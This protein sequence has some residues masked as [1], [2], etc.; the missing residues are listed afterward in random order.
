MEPILNFA[1]IPATTVYDDEMHPIGTAQLLLRFEETRTW[2]AMR[3][4][5]GTPYSTKGR[6]H[7][8]VSTGGMTRRPTAGEPSVRWPTEE[9]QLA[10]EEL[11]P[12]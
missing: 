1:S 4:I 8:S 3:F 5:E 7:I 12:L 10:D 2:G 9:E 6:L 11:I